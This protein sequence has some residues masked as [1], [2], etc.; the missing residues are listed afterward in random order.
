MTDN[1]ARRSLVYTFERAERLPE[2]TN[3]VVA[4]YSRGQGRHPYRVLHDRTL[5][6]ATGT[7]RIFV[8]SREIGR[9]VSWPTREDCRRI[10]SPSA[11]PRGAPIKLTFKQRATL[12]GLTQEE[13]ARRSGQRRSQLARQRANQVRREVA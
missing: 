8:E 1:L 13:K 11:P 10:E 3:N 5:G 6:G 9:Q 12:G 4:T 2:R 7:F